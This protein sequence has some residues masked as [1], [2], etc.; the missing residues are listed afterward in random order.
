MLGGFEKKGRWGRE[1]VGTLLK[2]LPKSEEEDTAFNFLQ[3][4]IIQN[5][6]QHKPISLIS[7]KRKCIC[8]IQSNHQTSQRNQHK[9]HLYQ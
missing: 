4:S 7:D 2:K 5:K 1:E 8:R 9:C 6:M 3:D